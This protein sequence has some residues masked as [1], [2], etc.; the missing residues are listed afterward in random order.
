MA[1]SIVISNRETKIYFKQNR[2]IFQTFLKINKHNLSCKKLGAHLKCTEILGKLLHIWSTFGCDSK[3]ALVISGESTGVQS[4]RSCS[5]KSSQAL[6]QKDR[7]MENISCF[8]H[9]ETLVWSASVPYFHPDD[10]TH[11][12]QS[13]KSENCTLWNLNSHFLYFELC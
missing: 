6:L 1:S 5:R 4:G 13:S 7:V 11:A 12:A 10:G 8:M 3:C 9:T 2:T